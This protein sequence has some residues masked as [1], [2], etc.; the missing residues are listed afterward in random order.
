MGKTYRRWENNDKKL[1]SKAR[2]NNSNAAY[3]NQVIRQEYFN[4]LEEEYNENKAF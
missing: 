2:R 3:T 4:S 1:A